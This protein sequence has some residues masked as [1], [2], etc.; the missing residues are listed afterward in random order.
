MTW[1]RR[2]DFNVTV[3]TSAARSKNAACSLGLQ[4]DS[5]RYPFL[6]PL[7]VLAFRLHS[8]GPGASI[9]QAAVRCLRL[10]GLP[11]TQHCSLWFLPP[12]SPSPPDCMPGPIFPSH[13]LHS[14]CH[15][16]LSQSQFI[17]SSWPY[18]DMHSPGRRGQALAASHAFI[19]PL[20]AT[21]TTITS[22]SSSPCPLLS[23]APMQVPLNGLG[24]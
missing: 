18:R 13:I 21:T 8:R 4:R 16:A 10:E 15:S 7:S 6:S 23:A 22:S 1:G 2:T 5:W 20:A 17:P 11:E 12:C 14:C 19:D 9:F 24:P 3:G